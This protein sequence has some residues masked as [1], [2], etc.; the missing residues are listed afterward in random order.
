[1]NERDLLYVRDTGEGL[2]ELQVWHDGK[3]IEMPL[4]LKQAS[5]LMRELAALVDT[6]VKSGRGGS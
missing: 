2:A 5:R 1:M 3:V 6:Y 4:S